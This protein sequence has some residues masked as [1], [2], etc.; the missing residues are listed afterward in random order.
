MEVGEEEVVQELRFYTDRRGRV[1]RVE[2]SNRTRTWQDQSDLAILL[3]EY[4]Q[5]KK[6]FDD[7]HAQGD[8]TR[9]GDLQARLEG[10][11][12]KIRM[13]ESAMPDGFVKREH[14][15]ADI[16]Y[17]TDESRRMGMNELMS[18]IDTDPRFV[19]APEDDMYGI[20]AKAHE[21][22]LPEHKHRLQRVESG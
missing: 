22:L 1:R 2:R 3:G 13:K 14:V 16:P 10:I 5:T 7:A 15:V 9:A 12:G 21:P 4:R 18:L 11:E 19:W 17:F 20:Y 6:A 8:E